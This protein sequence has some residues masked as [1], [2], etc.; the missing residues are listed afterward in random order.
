MA[1]RI[2]DPS[3]EIGRGGELP[4]RAI[5]KWRFAAPG[6]RPHTTMFVLSGVQSHQ[7]HSSRSPREIFLELPTRMGTISRYEAPGGRT[8]IDAPSSENARALPSPNRTA[9]VPSTFRT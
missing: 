1:Y 3:G 4:S 7:T 6:L 2:F 5:A 9:G 8:Q